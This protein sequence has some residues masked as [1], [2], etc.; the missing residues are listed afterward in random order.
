M[1]D[2]ERID[3]LTRRVRRLERDLARMT[4]LTR[5]LAADI[6]ARYSDWPV[7]ADDDSRILE[8]V[9]RRYDRLE[10]LPELPPEQPPAA[11]TP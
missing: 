10:D 11:P 4:L 1:T 5:T 3:H 8:R 7:A 6:T 9:L 2:T